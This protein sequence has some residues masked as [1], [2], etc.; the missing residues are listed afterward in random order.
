MKFMEKLEKTPYEEEKK[1][2]MC[3]ILIRAILEAE[4]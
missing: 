1:K 2:Q 3:E 4:I